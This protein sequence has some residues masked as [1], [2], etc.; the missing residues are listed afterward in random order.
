MMHLLGGTW[1]A[2]TLVGLEY[3]HKL[4]VKLNL[5]RVMLVVLGIGLAWE[6]YELFFGLTLT[7]QGGYL[8][9]TLSDL[10]FDLIGG[11]VLYGL[12]LRQSIV[13]P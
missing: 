4:P 12:V 13:A 9:D 11:Y 5:F 6:I 10:F 2:M 3:L 1:I 8:A 7:A